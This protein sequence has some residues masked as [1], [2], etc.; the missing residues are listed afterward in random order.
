MGRNNRLR[1]AFSI[2]SHFFLSHGKL[3]TDFFYLSSNKPFF[4]A[5]LLGM[6]VLQD[7]KTPQFISEENLQTIL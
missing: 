2:I 5:N 6:S 1:N 4:F 3:I 7:G